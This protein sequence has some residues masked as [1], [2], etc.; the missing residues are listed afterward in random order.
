[1][2]NSEDTLVTSFSAI[3]TWKLE[4]KSSHEGRPL[5][6]V[7]VFGYE[8]MLRFVTGV[9]VGTRRRGGGGRSAAGRRPGG[10]RVAAG[11]VRRGAVA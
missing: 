6:T 4:R 8:W 7:P 10:G 11:R 1:M 3:V 9:S 2:M 5:E